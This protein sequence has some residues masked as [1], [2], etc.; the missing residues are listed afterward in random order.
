MSDILID[1]KALDNTKHIFSKRKLSKWVDDDSVTKCYNCNTLFGF[2]VRK[3]HCRL[4]GRVYCHSCSNYYVKITPDII[5]KLPDKNIDIKKI[6]WNNH[7]EVRTCSSCHTQTN[8]LMKIRKIIKVFELCKFDLRDLLI[9]SYFS[10]NWKQASIFIMSKFRDIQYKLS[11]E[12]INKKEFDLLWNNYKYM[13][14]HNLWI[15]KLV[16][17][18]LTQ[19]QQELLK[20]ILNQKKVNSCEILLCSDKCDNNNI[21]SIMDF[22]IHNNNNAFMSEYVITQLSQYSNTQLKYY[23][24]LFVNKIDTNWFMVDFLISRGKNDFAFMVYIY[25]SIVSYNK[26]ITALFLAQISKNTTPEFMGKFNKML[27]M[28]TI[29]INM[30]S[31]LENVIL[32]IMPEIEF[33]SID[34]FV[35]IM[36]SNSR[37]KIFKFL[38]DDGSYKEIMFKI[39]DVRKDNI[40]INII[41]IVQNIL[42]SHNIDIDIVNY[43]VVPTGDNTGY[44][45]IINNATTIYDIVEVQKITIQNYI[46]NNNKDESIKKVRERFTKSTALYSMLCFLLSVGDRHLENIMVT[47]EGLLCHIDYNYILGNDPKYVTKNKNLRINT[48]IINA[49]GDD[50]ETFKKLCVDIYKILR[51]H[52]NL[53]ANLL[54][55][56]TETDKTITLESIKNILETRFEIGEDENDIVSHM[57]N[58]VT[59]NNNIDYVFI[60]FLHKSKSTLLYKNVS[61]ATEKLFS[62]FH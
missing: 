7:D 62:L 30:I 42:K 15:A 58:L 28:K 40:I 55:V 49:M 14:G 23:V 6:I 47:S 25:W 18:N 31:K 22:I 11:I 60:D 3:H 34:P 24:P 59:S 1:E 8:N 61:N 19:T 53:F 38:K 46:F 56:L 33:K 45:E 41:H 52:V 2:F 16:S 50:Y 9:L 54:S 13:K 35:K 26:K 29:D 36:D 27:S 48:E 21:N 12:K 44:I 39:D 5:Q 4:C 32:P 17:H 10:S 37:P 57:S 20:K 43:N 51:S